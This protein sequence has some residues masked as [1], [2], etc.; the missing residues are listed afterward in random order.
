MYI[1]VFWTLFTALALMG[2]G[3]LLAAFAATVFDS[4]KNWSNESPQVHRIPFGFHGS[5]QRTT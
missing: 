1:S 2:A 4:W 3:V 5:H